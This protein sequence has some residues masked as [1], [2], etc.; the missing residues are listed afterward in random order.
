VRPPDAVIETHGLSKRYRVY[1]GHGR[2]WLKSVVFPPRRERYYVEN[3]ALTDVDLRVM[4]GEVVGIIGRNGS[5]KSTLLRVVAGMS[6]PTAGRVTVRGRPR[7][8]LAA[9]VGF[10]PNL[11]GRENIV[12][13]SVVMGIPKE[14][15]ITRL[16]EIVEF[17]EIG[18]HIDQPTRFYSNGMRTRLALA[19]TL[20]EVPEI[21]MLDEAFGG[22][23]AY[24]QLKCAD[25][26]AQVCER[27]ST[28]LLVT[29]STTLVDRLCTRALIMDGGR[30]VADG[31]PEAVTARYMRGVT[32]PGSS[33]GGRRRQRR[34]A[35][36][37]EPAGDATPDDSPMRLLDAY[38][39]GDDG[40]RRTEFDHGESLELHLRVRAVD[41]VR[42]ARF[43]LELYSELFDTRITSFGTEHLSAETKTLEITPLRDLEGDYDLTLRWPSNPLGS[44]RYY[45]NL[46]VRPFAA[47][48]LSSALPDHFIRVLKLCPFESTSFPGHRFGKRRVALIEPATEIRL[49]R[50]TGA[51]R[52]AVTR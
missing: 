35:L 30:I 7:C 43:T 19:V 36:A 38:M 39:T 13:G 45:W 18:A 23:D 51:P 14:V 42:T 2:G 8:L 49:E 22:G 16:D 41:Q 4:Q 26:L 24:F 37:S 17:A 44:G 15:A 32:E 29:H 34:G 27:G 47:P 3:T 48:D 52:A 10:N 46:S 9:G 21:L 20:Q 11:T 40:R 28:I 6:Q 12:F 5:G 25:R 50:V 1:H 31:F 33:P